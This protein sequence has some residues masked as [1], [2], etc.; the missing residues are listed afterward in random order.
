MQ[1]LYHQQYQQCDVWNLVGLIAVR[2]FVRDLSRSILS[3][4]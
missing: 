1:D 2:T 4:K 3:H